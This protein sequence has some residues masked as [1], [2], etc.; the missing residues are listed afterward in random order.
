MSSTTSAGS[1][2]TADWR[3]SSRSQINGN[4]LEARFRKSSH[5]F[6]EANCTEAA[7]LGDVVAVR[8]SKQAPKPGC[9]GPEGPH[10]EFSPADWSAF[11]EGIKA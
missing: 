6:H 2:L 11:L 9:E 5:S 10:L 1:G 3:K 8:D 7:L 4:C